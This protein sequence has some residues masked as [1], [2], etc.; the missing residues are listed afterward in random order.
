MT[1]FETSVNVQAPPAVIWRLLSRV[2]DW[3]SWTPTVTSVEALDGPELAVGARFRLRQPKLRPAVWT[4]RS[5]SAGREFVWG[6]AGAGLQVTA[7]HSIAAAS[8]GATR[9]T[10]G[11]RLSGVLAPVLWPLA[12]PLTRQYVTQEVEALKA[13]AERAA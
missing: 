2:G 6:K 3:P 5:V 4:V 13:A 12:G 11:V 8:S 7:A 1:G 9:L 10:I